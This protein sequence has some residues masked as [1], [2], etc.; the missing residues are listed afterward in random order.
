MQGN[1]GPRVRHFKWWQDLDRAANLK[2]KINKG[3]Y[4]R[5]L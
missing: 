2:A 3:I 4:G 1:F 5:K